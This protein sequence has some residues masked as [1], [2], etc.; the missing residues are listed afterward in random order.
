MICGPG[1]HVEHPTLGLAGSY[2][3]RLDI[4]DMDLCICIC[5][6][7]IYICWLNSIRSRC[8]WSFQPGG[9]VVSIEV[10]SEEVGDNCQKSPDSMDHRW[11]TGSEKRSW[12]PAQG[13]PAYSALQVRLWARDIS[14]EDLSWVFALLLICVMLF[15][16]LYWNILWISY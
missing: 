13:A 14:F 12:W 15:M 2:L 16:V 11:M 8:F 7:G 5:W 4:H 3:G 9:P 1:L 6:L 10:L